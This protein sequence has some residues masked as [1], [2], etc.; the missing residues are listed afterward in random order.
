MNMSEFE[1]MILPD[2]FQMDTTPEEAPEQPEVQEE[3]VEPV[4]DT[5]P[6]EPTEEPVEEPIQPFLRVKYNKEELEL[7]QDRAKE[8]AQKGLNYDKLQERYQALESDPRLSFV[9]ELARQHGM[10]VNEYVE[11][12]RQHQE[13]ERIN[14]LV[15]QGIS[16]ELAQEMLENRKFR[17][18]F[19]AEKKAKEEQTKKDAQ[20]QE[21]FNYFREANGRE[22]VPNQDEIPPAVWQ[23]HE[24]GVPLK[25]AFMEHQNNQY[26]TQIQMLQQNKENEKKA[27]IGSLSAHGSQEVASEDDFLKGFNSI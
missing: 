19:E 3:P 1:D 17:D 27:P 22:F 9:E 18:Q 25:Y 10:D 2:D 6:T 5:K 20:Y 21:F 16:E 13:Q 12:V 26:K 23:A 11:A 15:Q 7:D 24:S 4:E 14:E 8:L